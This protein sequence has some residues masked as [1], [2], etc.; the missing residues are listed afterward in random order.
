MM[1]PQW[2]PRESYPEKAYGDLF[3]QSGPSVP[4][5]SPD[6]DKISRHPVIRILRQIDELRSR[7]EIE[8]RI[9]RQAERTRAELEV[10]LRAI[11]E[12]P[13]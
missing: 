1:F 10:C 8:Q 2:Q 7:G 5:Q 4:P 9:E 11:H 6:A 3:A 12:S 13:N